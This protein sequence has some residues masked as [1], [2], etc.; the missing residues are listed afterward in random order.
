M[1]ISGHHFI[2]FFLALLYKIFGVNLFVVRL[3]QALLG[4][5]S[6]GFLFLIGKRLFNRRSGL[7]A[8]L[9]M[10]VYPLFIYFDGEL[11]IPVVLIFLVL[12]GFV[13]FL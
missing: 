4:A 6:C 8:G 2:R 3:V 10:A 11:L 9:L 5:V 1:P 13:A 7:A 12:A